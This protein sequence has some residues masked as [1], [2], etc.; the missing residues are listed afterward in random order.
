MKKEES[1]RARFRG[2]K[3]EIKEYGKRE[4]EGE[5]WRLFCNSR[6]FSLLGFTIDKQHNATQ[7]IK[8]IKVNQ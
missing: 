1:N 8:H 3:R 5:I 4:K 7:H 2:E 6:F